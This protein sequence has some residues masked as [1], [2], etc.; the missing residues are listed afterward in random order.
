MIDKENMSNSETSIGE[1]MVVK[2]KINQ[3]KKN[4]TKTIKGDGKGE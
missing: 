4:G 2:R 3:I 1:L